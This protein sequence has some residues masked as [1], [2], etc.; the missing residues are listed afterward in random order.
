MISLLLVMLAA[1]QQGAPDSARVVEA[2]AT[3]SRDT[4]LIGQPFDLV[5]QLNGLG[6]GE[7]VFFPSFDE[8][9]LVTPL[10][11]PEP[12]GDHPE[13]QAAARYRLAVWKAGER[14]LLADSIVLRGGAPGGEELAIAWPETRIFVASAL[15]EGSDAE[16]LAWRPPADV[17]GSNWGLRERILGAALLLA[18]LVIVGIYARR[19]AGKGQPVPIPEPAPPRER[20]MRTLYDLERSQ[21]VEAGELKAFYSALSGTLRGFLAE[22]VPRW[23]R[24]LT[25]AELMRLTGDDGIDDEASRILGEVLARSDRVKFGRRRPAEQ[26]ARRDIAA[27]KLWILKFEPPP[28]PTTDPEAV[29][30]HDATLLSEIGLV[31]ADVGERGYSE[32]DGRSEPR[33]VDPTGDEEPGGFREGTI[34]GEG[35]RGG[36]QR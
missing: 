4:V 1:P 22:S 24:D 10:A 14:A 15:P 19:R 28:E 16:S 5:L 32:G 26:T 20:A 3:V 11:A 13:G 35:G 7:E 12:L 8:D 34:G 21:M 2:T 23:S 9:A 18:V 6:Q 27:A 36:T 33:I 31:F 25:T 17:M 30:G 29:E